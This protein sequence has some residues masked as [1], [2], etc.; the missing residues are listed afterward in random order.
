M[1]VHIFFSFEKEKKK[2]TK[3]RR[4]KSKNAAFNWSFFDSDIVKLSNP[5][6][7]TEMFKLSD[8]RVVLSANML[9]LKVMLKIEK[10]YRECNSTELESIITYFEVSFDGWC[11]GWI[12]IIPEATEKNKAWPSIEYPA[13]KTALPPEL[14]SNW[15]GSS[16]DPV[17]TD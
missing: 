8:N 14:K 6:W 4:Q 11:E 1:L 13:P 12:V 2:L 5:A 7:D 15:S 3:S 17:P 10:S 16:I 9:S